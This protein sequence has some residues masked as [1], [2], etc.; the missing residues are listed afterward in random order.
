[1]GVREHLIDG[2]RI[3]L[4]HPPFYL[5]TH[6]LLRCEDADGSDLSDGVSV[7]CVRE[8]TSVADVTDIRVT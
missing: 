4:Q 5:T 6:R 7:V 1:M 8:C 2:E 3:V